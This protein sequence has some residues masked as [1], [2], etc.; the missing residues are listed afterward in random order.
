MNYL[1]IQEKMKYKI[2]KIAWAVYL[3]AM[4]TTESELLADLL[5]EARREEKSE[6]ENAWLMQ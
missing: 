3:W 5:E 2:A 4:N 1:A 6:R